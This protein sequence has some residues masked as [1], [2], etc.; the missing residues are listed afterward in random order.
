MS[1]GEKSKQEGSVGEGEVI[2]VSVEKKDSLDLKELRVASA[3][4][5][6]SWPY[7]LR[8]LGIQ[9]FPSLG[10]HHCFP[11]AITPAK[12]TGI[13]DTPWLPG[14]R[15][16]CAGLFSSSQ[17]SSRP[18]SPTTVTCD[19]DEGGWACLPYPPQ[20]RIL[21]PHLS[22]SPS[23]SVGPSNHKASLPLLFWPQNQPPPKMTGR[24]VFMAQTDNL[25][26]KHFDTDLM[27]TVWGSL[28]QPQAPSYKII[29]IQKSVNIFCK[30]PDR[31]LPW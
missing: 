26:I 14:P 12:L 16:P 4:L 29:L 13:R 24:K 28:S 3:G 27:P 8:V 19:K 9:M 31:R 1:Q 6:A 20:G 17:N 5:R 7:P 23:P 10:L 11:Q 30:G 15:L 25:Q 18:V 21:H 2:S 22:S